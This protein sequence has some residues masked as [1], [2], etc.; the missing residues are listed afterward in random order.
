MR[1]GSLALTAFLLCAAASGREP[2]PQKMIVA[3]P[4]ADIRATQR[5]HDRHYAQ[6]PDQETQVVAGEP[7]LVKERKGRWLRV[8]CPEQPEF[9]HHNVWEGY[10]GWIEASAVTS[11]LSK[12][13]PLVARQGSE[14]ELRRAVLD[15][16]EKHLGE[17]YL[18]GGRSFHDNN[19][20]R[21]VTGVDCSG[22]VN[23]SFRKIGRVVPRDAQEQFMRARR[24]DPSKLQPG[25]LIFSGKPDKPGKVTH[26]ALYAGDDM[27]LEAPQSGE[28]V[29]KISAQKKYGR[30]LSEISNGEKVGDRVI[31]FG[32]LFDGQ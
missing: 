2:T 8:E 11:D 20:R 4:V 30:R 28:A 24:V 25:D 26:V 18:W 5:P 23:L 15:E 14:R 12:E 13:T 1:R 16:A 7:V 9:T 22:L 32:T 31:Y 10:P 17:A 6:D 21:T 27:I 3:V 19:Y 29:R